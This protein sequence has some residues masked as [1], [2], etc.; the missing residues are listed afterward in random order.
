MK[1]F[2]GIIVLFLTFSAYAVDKS[3]GCGA[4]WYVTNSGQ[5]EENQRQPE[6][7]A[8][9]QNAGKAELGGQ[10]RHQGDA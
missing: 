9:S 10:H 5:E 6:Y 1:L 7:V 3:S 4:G 2:V 8:K